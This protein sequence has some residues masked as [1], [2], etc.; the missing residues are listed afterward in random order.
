MHGLWYVLLAVIQFVIIKGAIKMWLIRNLKKNLTYKPIIAVITII[1]G[2]RS[3]CI[4]WS[5]RSVRKRVGLRA[6][7]ALPENHGILTFYTNAYACR[8]APLLEKILMNIPSF[9]SKQFSRNLC[10][11]RDNERSLRVN[12]KIATNQSM[13]WTTSKVQVEKCYCTV[14]VPYSSSFSFVCWRSW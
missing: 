8:S 12:S 4:V 11:C 5:L 6:G 2:I 13:F 9:G 14:Q 10:R 3:R 7:C 1:L